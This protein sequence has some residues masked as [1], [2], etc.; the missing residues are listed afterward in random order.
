M[1][2]ICTDISQN[3]GVHNFSPRPAN[4]LLIVFEV[5][6]AKTRSIT[7]ETLVIWYLVLMYCTRP[8]FHSSP[9]FLGFFP[10]FILLF[11]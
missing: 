5:T 10:T 2:D 1:T 11:P 4:T 7:W 8:A 9:S 3:A 6:F